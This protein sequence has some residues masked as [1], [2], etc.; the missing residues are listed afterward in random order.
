[1]TDYWLP[2]HER[3]KLISLVADQP[4]QTI[5]E[6]EA[7]AK[8]SDRYMV[9]AGLVSLVNACQIRRDGNGR[10]WPLT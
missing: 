10:L 7:A 1:M 5:E 4:G 2:P 6:H 9:R 3:D 8:I